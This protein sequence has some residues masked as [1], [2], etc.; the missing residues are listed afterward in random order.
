MPKDKSAKRLFDDPFA[1]LDDTG[2]TDDGSAKPE[3]ESR[4]H[5]P[6]K[7]K[8]EKKE[9]AAAKPKSST[10]KRAKKKTKS[11]TK[12]EQ[13]PAAAAKPKA[14]SQKRTAKKT[15]TKPKSEQKPAAAAKPKTASRQRTAKKTATKPKSEQKPAAAAKPKTA[16]RQRTAKKTTPKP[17]SEKKPA[18]AV[19]PKAAPQK[20]ATKK[21][22]EKPRSEKKPTVATKSKSIPRKRT[23]K[24]ATLKSKREE[25]PAAAAKTEFRVER[26][27]STVEKPEVPSTTG[28]DGVIIDSQVADQDLPDDRIAIGSSHEIV[29]DPDKG[30]TLL[31]TLIASIDEGD[32]KAMERATMAALPFVRKIEAIEGEQH[33]VFTVGEREYAVAI[34]NVV[35]IGEPLNTTPVP[36]VP[37]WVL[38]VAN[39]RGDIV[40][41]IDLRVFMGLPEADPGQEKKM[42]VARSSDGEI[43]T[44]VLVDQVR[45]IRYLKLD[46]LVQPT[47]AAK[48]LFEEFIDGVCENEGQEF[49]VLDI[50]RVLSSERMRIK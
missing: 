40:S 20:Q 7:S 43:S 19:K 18:A 49:V 17:K 22:A 27:T 23:V 10:R 35:E 3:A 46:Q 6:E 34:D 24:K 28:M 21:T 8:R 26:S 29:L 31:E 2:K 30:R 12:P 37:E 25:K 11:K 41:V 9:T 15:T 1:P 14:A 13:K 36:N 48:D 39:L 16:S 44:C 45:G 38:G 50:D 42:L 4:K 5:P 47:A 32:E 33:V